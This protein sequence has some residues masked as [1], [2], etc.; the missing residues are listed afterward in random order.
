[1]AA[2]RICV[3]PGDGIGPEVMREALAVLRTVETV[4]GERQFETVEELVGGA[5]YDAH[6]TPMTP[7][8]LALA[9]ASDALLLG[10]VGGPKWDVLPFDLRPERGLLGLRRELGLFANLRPAVVFAPLI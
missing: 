7:G 4:S 9:K 8:A 6:G 10:A 2:K 3:F 5:S 1:M